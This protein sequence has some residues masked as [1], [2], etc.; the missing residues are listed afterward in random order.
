[1]FVGIAASSR[2]LLHEL[3]GDD[4][5]AQRAWQAALAAFEDCGMAGRAAAVRMRIPEQVD[6]GLAYFEREHVGGWQRF[7]E[8]CAPSVRAI[9]ALPPASGSG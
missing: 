1:M 3:D 7:V 2:A 8:V 5:A 4:P 9:A 6:Q